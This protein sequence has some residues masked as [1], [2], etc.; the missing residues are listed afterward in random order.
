MNGMLVKK[1][2]KVPTGLTIFIKYF[3][4]YIYIY[5]YIYNILDS[6]WKVCHIIKLRDN[7]AFWDLNLSRMG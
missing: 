6:I 5:I 7:T 4:K 3:I 1:I 2:R